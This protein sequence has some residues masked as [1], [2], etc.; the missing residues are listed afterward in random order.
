MDEIYIGSAKNSIYGRLW[1]RVQDPQR[2]YDGASQEAWRNGLTIQVSWATTADSDEAERH[3]YSLIRAYREK[4]GHFPCLVLDGRPLSGNNQ[5]PTCKGDPG[6][7]LCWSKWADLFHIRYSNDEM[8]D[9][10][11]RL[12]IPNCPGVYRFRLSG[13]QWGCLW[14]ADRKK[15]Q[16]LSIQHPGC[17]V[18]LSHHRGVRDYWHRTGRGDRNAKVNEVDICRSC[19]WI[20]PKEAKAGK[21]CA[22]CR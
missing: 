13:T 4:H 2:Y 19:H 11:K 9:R 18:C 16:E 22:V 14:V 20:V 1:E 3:E 7:S 5:W 8:K 12:D 15:A 21:Y 17:P 10:F 6:K